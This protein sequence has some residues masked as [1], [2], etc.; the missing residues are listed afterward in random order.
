VPG[1]RGLV[2]PEALRF[3]V[4]DRHIEV[5]C[6]DPRIRDAIAANY[7]AF[8][9]DDAGCATPLRYRVA[10]DPSSGGFVLAAPGEVPS[11]SSSVAELVFDLEKA[12]TIALQQ[13]RPELLFLHAAALQREGRACLLAG[14]SGSGKS[15]TCWGLLHHG[16]RYLSD[17]LA[18]VDLGS[19]QVLAYPHALC[20]KQRP[21]AGYPLP[22]DAVNLDTT[23]HVPVRSLP[24]GASIS[25][26]PLGAVIFVRHEAG[27]DAPRSSEIG[28][29]EAAARLYLCTLNALAHPARGL[30]AVLQV[31]GRV[32]CFSLRAADLHDTCELI[33]RLV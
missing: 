23:I 19:G 27:L 7:A 5:A 16:F 26:C 24:G 30:D 12:L 32:P 28:T 21:P 11:L 25:P 3:C 13:Q 18:P 15:T 9:C 33:S 14:E 4:F 20:L 6:G 8:L 17:E 22:A 31:V 1:P 10:T 29:A 2:A